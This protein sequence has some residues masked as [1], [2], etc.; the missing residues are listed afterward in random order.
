M[1]TYQSARTCPDGISTTPPRSEADISLG[2][3]E[4][5]EIERIDLSKIASAITAPARQPIG[6]TISGTRKDGRTHDGASWDPTIAIC[7]P[8]L[9]P[10]WCYSVSQD[11]T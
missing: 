11:R 9:A 8:R 3:R 1:S 10:R 2:E 4:T 5:G 7:Q 6:S